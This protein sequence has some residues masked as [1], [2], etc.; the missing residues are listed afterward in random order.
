MKIQK[1]LLGV[2]MLSF[3]TGLFFVISTNNIF[4]FDNGDKLIKQSILVSNKSGKEIPKKVKPIENEFI[5]PYD[6]AKNYGGSELLDKGYFLDLDRKYKYKLLEIGE[7]HGDQINAKSGEKWLGIFAAHTGIF[8]K[9]TKIKVTR[10]HDVIVDDNPVQKT[11]KKVSVLGESLP[12]LLINGVKDFDEGEVKTYF[13]GL[14]GN[15]TPGLEEYSTDIRKDFS[16]KYNV[17]GEIYTLH[18]AKVFDKQGAERFVLLFESSKKKQII[19]ISRE[20][21]YLG[22]L[23]WV[24]DLD[25]DGKPDIFLSPWIQENTSLNILLL[26]SE[27][28]GNKLIKVA[29]ILATSGC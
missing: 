2:F 11:G 3:L 15:E 29:A 7:Y 4:K 8:V 9:K 13:K 20:E 14:T 18:T 24:G 12:F 5:I 19:H 6:E 28:E 16:Q 21:D 10:V 22:E 17:N 25:R 26:S 1:I 23:F 27:A